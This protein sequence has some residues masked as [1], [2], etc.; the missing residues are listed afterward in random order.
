MEIYPKK[1]N[2][3]DYTTQAIKVVGTLLVSESEDKP[4]TDMYGYEFNFKIVDATYS[5]I[6]DSE[7]SENMALWQ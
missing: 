6:N 2:S 3:F 4:F 1:G 7:L 5:I